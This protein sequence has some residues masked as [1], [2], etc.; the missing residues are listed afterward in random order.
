M[1]QKI[2]LALGFGNLSGNAH[3]PLLAEDAANLS[4]LFEV[5]HKSSALPLPAAQVLFVYAALSEDGC[6]PGD[7]TGASAELAHI[8]RAP[9]V[10]LASPT[11]ILAAKKVLLAKRPLK[12]N[13]VVTLERKGQAFG[14]FFHALFELMRDGEDMLTAWVTLCPQGPISPPNLPLTLMA[15]GAGKL[16]F[17][18]KSD[19]KSTEKIFTPS[20]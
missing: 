15:A 5:V 19:C 8:T 16:T 6:V 2:P 11:P 10:I 12:A 13:V 4:S 14:K 20:G 17:P 18:R 9:I 7:E 1:T 3:A